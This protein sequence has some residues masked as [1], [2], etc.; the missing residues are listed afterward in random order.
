[1]IK[2]HRH[3]RV[4]VDTGP[5]VAILNQHDQNHQLCTE[6]LKQIEPPLLTCWAVLTEA[7]WLLRSD[8]EATSRLLLRASG[9]FQLLDLG[10]DDLPEIHRL[11][12]R[13]LDLSPQFADLA[14]VCLAQREGIVT[15]FTTDRRDFSVYRYKGKSGFHLLPEGPV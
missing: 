3:R 15:V 6:A 9:L 11:Y 8:A 1:V 14:L 5:I 12:K 13:Y 4:L 2:R 7:A 10:Q